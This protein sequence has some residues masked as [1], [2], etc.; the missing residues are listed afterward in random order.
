MQMFFRQRK[1]IKYTRQRTLSPLASRL[2]PVQG[3]PEAGRCTFLAPSDEVCEGG[4]R[5]KRKPCCYRNR[6]N[7]SIGLS[8]GIGWS[9]ILWIVYD[10]WNFYW[11]IK[12]G[13]HFNAI[14]GGWFAVRIYNQGRPR[15]R[16]TLS[17]KTTPKGALQQ[18][19]PRNP[20]NIIT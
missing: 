7:T 12:L 20:V 19:F 5:D 9:G 14:R 3:I 6:K 15:D 10:A 8:L 4:R 11:I 2:I 13:V 17:T 16:E 1:S 18:Q